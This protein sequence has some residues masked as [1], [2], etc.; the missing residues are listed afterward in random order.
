MLT[1]SA[2]DSRELTDTD[3]SWLCTVDQSLYPVSS[4]VSCAAMRDWLHRCPGLGRVYHARSLPHTRLGVF[5]CA[6]LSPLGWSRLVLRG[7]VCEA[8]LSV[9]DLFDPDALDE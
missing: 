1:W 8:T 7:E 3:L 6:P 9:A 2:V 4:P 5:L